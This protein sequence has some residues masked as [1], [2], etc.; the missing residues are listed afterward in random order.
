MFKAAIAAVTVAAVGRGGGGR[1]RPIPRPPTAAATLLT[2]E[3]GSGLKRRRPC[4][5]KYLRT[6]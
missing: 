6:V 5:H 2:A 1:C 4:N 3:C